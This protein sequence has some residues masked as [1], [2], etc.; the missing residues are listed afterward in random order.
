MIR[1]GIY[2]VLYFLNYQKILSSGKVIHTCTNICNHLA[3]AF[4]VIKIDMNDVI[5]SCVVFEKKT[6]GALLEGKDSA[7]WGALGTSLQDTKI[8]VD[9]CIF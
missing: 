2:D 1:E 3:E 9:E 7:I 4:Y 8:F 6:Y 5:M